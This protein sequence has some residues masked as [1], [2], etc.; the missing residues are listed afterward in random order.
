MTACFTFGYLLASRGPHWGA[1]LRTLISFFDRC[2][3]ASTIEVKLKPTKSQL[4]KNMVVFK[5]RGGNH[6]KEICESVVCDQ[7]AMVLIP[8]RIDDTDL[9]RGIQ[10]RADLR[11]EGAS[12]PTAKQ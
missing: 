11:K 2:H 5:T 4:R 9:L 7:G 12:E 3:P 10:V 6:S 1:Y 8:R